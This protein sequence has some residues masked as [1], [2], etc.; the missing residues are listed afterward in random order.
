MFHVKQF[1]L[2]RCKL[3]ILIRTKLEHFALAKWEYAVF[4]RPNL[5][6][7]IKCRY[8]TMTIDT[9]LRRYDGRAGMTTLSRSPP[10]WA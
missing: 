8:D 9:G 5:D 3:N 6:S 10:P 7:G 1:G 4:Y 2:F